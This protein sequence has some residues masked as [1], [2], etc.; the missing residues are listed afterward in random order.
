[1]LSDWAFRS[2]R[3]E[4]LE[5][6]TLLG[7]VASERVA[8]KAGY[9][10][11]EEMHDYVHPAKPDQP[12]RAKR[13]VRTSDAGAERREANQSRLGRRARRRGPASLGPTG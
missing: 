11:A 10:M 12:F 3:L 8:E 2:F 6:V 13:W 1:M 5:L 7:N 4:R 9:V